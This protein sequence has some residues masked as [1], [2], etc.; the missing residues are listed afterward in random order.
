MA[1]GEG[2]GLLLGT[3]GGGARNGGDAASELSFESS[4][5]VSLSSAATA[6]TAADAATA[7]LR[8]AFVKDEYRGG[9]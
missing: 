8:A 5:K 4:D 9:W 6:S 2:T 3:P 1:D 7:L